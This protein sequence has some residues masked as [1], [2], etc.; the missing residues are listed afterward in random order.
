MATFVATL[1]KM[2]DAADLKECQVRNELTCRI[3]GTENGLRREEGE[4]R[5]WWD[6]VSRVACNASPR[7]RNLR[8]DTR[9]EQVL[10]D[11]RKG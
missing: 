4:L 2:L 3:S 1:I 5:C 10:L 8:P 6:L 9:N 7:C 11:L